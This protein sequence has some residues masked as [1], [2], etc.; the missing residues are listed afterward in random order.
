MATIITIG[1]I[2][3][4]KS[5][6]HDVIF[7]VVGMQP[8]GHVELKGIILRLRADAPSNDLVKLSRNKVVTLGVVRQSLMLA[9]RIKTSD[10]LSP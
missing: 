9:R 6:N 7:K 2:V 10:I 1:E 3:T 8:N 4:R 5:H